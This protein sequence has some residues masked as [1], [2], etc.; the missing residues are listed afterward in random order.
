[1][2]QLLWIYSQ[3]LSIHFNILEYSPWNHTHTLIRASI[4]QNL[5]IRQLNK[6]LSIIQEN[7]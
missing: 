1:M 3:E 5:P 2:T 7:L 6:V 4:A